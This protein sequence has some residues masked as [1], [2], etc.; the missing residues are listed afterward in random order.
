MDPVLVAVNAKT[1]ATYVS[2]CCGETI[3][4]LLTETDD[5]RTA[6]QA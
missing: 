6:Q 3:S 5:E 1:N 2:V 4:K